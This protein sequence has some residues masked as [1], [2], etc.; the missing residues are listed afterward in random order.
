VKKTSLQG[1]LNRPALCVSKPD[2]FWPIPDQFVGVEIEL[3]GQSAK[4]VAAHRNNGRPF[5]AEHEDGSL[6]GGIEYVLAQPTMGNTLREAIHYFFRNFKTFTES[7]RTSIHVHLNMLQENETLEGLKNMVVLYYMFENAFFIIA[8]ENRKWNGYCNPFEDNPPEVM[9]TILGVP[10]VE[11]LRGSLAVS[12]GRNTNRYYGL[13][14]NSLQKYGTLEFRHLPLVRDEE[15][16]FSWIKLLMELKKAANIMADEGTSPEEL[17][18]T[19]DDLG[20]LEKYMPLFGHTLLG[21]V[22]TGEAF[23]RLSAVVTLGVREARRHGRVGNNKAFARFQKVQM[24]EGRSVSQKP[25]KATSK[26]SL[27]GAFGEIEVQAVGGEWAPPRGRPVRVRMQP[28]PAMPGALVQAE[29]A[30]LGP[31]EGDLVPLML[32]PQAVVPRAQIGEEELV[33]LQDQLLFER[34]RQLAAQ[35]NRLR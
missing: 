23:V 3:E 18:K 10:D 28:G 14:I 22:G 33:G 29:E 30:N 21:I 4:E 35:P 27:N 16:L 15:R 11:E 31:D 34:M 24:E 7:P 19:P 26:K 9:A 25:K 12:A 32:P 1:V 6:R 13:N 17:F 20:L 8:D 2:E 5:W